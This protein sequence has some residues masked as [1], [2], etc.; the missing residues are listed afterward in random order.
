MRRNRI[1]RKIQVEAE[2]GQ[3]E[4][5]NYFLCII[6]GAFAKLRKAALILVMSV[7]PSVRPHG[8]TRLTLDGF[9]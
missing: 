9:S 8:S 6:S 2:R 5:G 3:R 1:L 7:R 4:G